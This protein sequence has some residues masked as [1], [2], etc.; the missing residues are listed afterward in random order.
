[1][2]LVIELVAAVVAVTYVVVAVA[3][4]VLVTVIVPYQPHW[5]EVS[6]AD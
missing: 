5:K 4:I 6:S 1:M 2:P 3:G